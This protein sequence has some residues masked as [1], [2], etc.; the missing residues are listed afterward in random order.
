MQSTQRTAPVTWWTRACLAAPALVMRQAL[1]LAATGI[2]GSAKA[3]VWR[4]V[5]RASCAGCMRAQWKGA[6]TWSMTVL[7]GSGLFAE[8]G[9]EMDGSGGSRDDG[10]VG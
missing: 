5:A 3:R 4:S 7:L 2:C 6:L 1:T 9:G 10:L 8:V